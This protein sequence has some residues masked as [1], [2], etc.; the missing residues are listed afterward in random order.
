MNVEPSRTK[1]FAGAVQGTAVAVLAAISVCHMLNDV[2]QSL[3]MAI[4]PMLKTS[5]ALDLSLIHI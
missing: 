2:I 4:Y 3:I 5:L 1:D